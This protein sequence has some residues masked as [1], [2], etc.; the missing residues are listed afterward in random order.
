LAPNV[1]AHWQQLAEAQ[2]F[3]VANNP[4]AAESSRA[5]FLDCLQREPQR[6]DCHCWLGRL[7]HSKGNHT[8]A[9]QSFT[10]AAEHGASCQYQLASELLELGELEQFN[11][12]VQTQLARIARPGNLARLYEL[13]ELELRIAVQRGDLAQARAARQRLAENAL[14]LSPEVAFNLGSTYAIAQPERPI[15]AKQLLGRFVQSSCDDRHSADDCH[16]CVVARDLLA[17]LA[18]TAP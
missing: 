10:R 18:A 6:G 2:F 1:A 4:M 15:E 11:L 7:Q 5:A 16:Q 9:L 8:A 17:H 3:N 12:V 13:Q 14:G